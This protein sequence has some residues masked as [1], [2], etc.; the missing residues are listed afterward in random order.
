MMSRP[1]FWQSDSA[2]SYM[3]PREPRPTRTYEIPLNGAVYSPQPVPPQTQ[4]DPYLAG[5]LR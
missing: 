4:Y 3:P 5:H 2:Q 1:E